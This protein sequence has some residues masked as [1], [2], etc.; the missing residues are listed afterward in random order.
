MIED[1]KTYLQ[2]VKKYNE[3]IN[4]KLTELYRRRRKGGKTVDE[5]NAEINRLIDDYVDYKKAVTEKIN[6]LSDENQRK[7]LMMKY[8]QFLSYR[9][10]AEQLFYS[11]S[12]V[13]RIHNKAL[14]NLDK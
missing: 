2:R 4:N 7:V 14:Y 1:T 10:I 8:I 5:L 3:Q 11:V 12:N 13:K 9:E 6:T